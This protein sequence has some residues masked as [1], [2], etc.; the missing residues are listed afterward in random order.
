MAWKKLVSQPQVEKTTAG[1]PSCATVHLGGITPKPN[2]A[3]GVDLGG[4]GTEDAW[5]P[6]RRGPHDVAA[7]GHGAQ[8]ERGR[9]RERGIAV[10]G[11]WRCLGLAPPLALVLVG[12]GGGIVHGGGLGFRREEDE[13]KCRTGED[14]E[15][16]LSWRRAVQVGL[17][18][19]DSGFHCFT[20]W[21]VFSFFISF[22]KFKIH[23]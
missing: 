8:P 20:H 9:P 17:G 7:C 2:G 21:S 14:E 5:R 12:G 3:G 4:A 1:A 19:I 22:S 18:W 16:R 13:P 10:G 6:R 11:G 23:F 15:C